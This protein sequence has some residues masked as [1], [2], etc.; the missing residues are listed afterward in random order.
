MSCGVMSQMRFSE[1]RR[2]ISQKRQTAS[3]LWSCRSP[4]QRRKTT[5]LNWDDV[6]VIIISE[7]F[8]RNL[9]LF[10]HDLKLRSNLWHSEKRNKHHPKTARI[11]V[12]SK[13]IWCYKKISNNYIY[14]YIFG[15]DTDT[16]LWLL[17]FLVPD[18]VLLVQ[19][20]EFPDWF[21]FSGE[22]IRLVSWLINGSNLLFFCSLHPCS[23]QKCVAT[24][25]GWGAGGVGGF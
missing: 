1:R 13:D 21:V 14:I 12:F 22:M 6:I 4:R 2:S 25:G 23:G 9:R 3:N 20:L 17:W 24:A 19:G 7:M 16:T 15:S 5:S 8:G 18:L 10:G 11:K